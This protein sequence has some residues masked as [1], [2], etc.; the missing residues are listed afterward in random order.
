MISVSRATFMKNEI[1]TIHVDWSHDTSTANT[2]ALVYILFFIL[3]GKFLIVRD[4]ALL[5]RQEA[6]F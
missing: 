4:Q 6:R 5:I 1:S 3:K 2:I